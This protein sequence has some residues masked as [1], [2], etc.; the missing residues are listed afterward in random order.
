MDGVSCFTEL[1]VFYGYTGDDDEESMTNDY[2][3]RYIIVRE[4]IKPDDLTFYLADFDDNRV[5]AC[6]WS[7]NRGNAHFFTRYNDAE[8]IIRWLESIKIKAKIDTQ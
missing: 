6:L 8:L 1:Y 7:R 2:G 4:K 3:V 5:H